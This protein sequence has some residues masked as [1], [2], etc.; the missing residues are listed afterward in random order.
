MPWV[1]SESQLCPILDM[2]GRRKALSSKTKSGNHSACGN[3]LKPPAPQCG[4]N[5]C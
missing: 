5:E 3:D 2:K 1:R 4:C